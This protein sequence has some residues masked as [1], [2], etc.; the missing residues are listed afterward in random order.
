MSDAWLFSGGKIVTPQGEGPERRDLLLRDGMIQAI[1]EQID[2]PDDGRVVDCSGKL[3]LPGM[4]DMHVHAREPGR[5]DLE[6][7]RTASEA[8]INGGVTG[9]LAMPNTDP[10]V[11]TGSKIQFIHNLPDQNARIPVITAG[12]VSKNRSGNELAEIGDM[13]DKGALMITDDGDPV[14]DP[15]LLRRAMEYTRSFPLIV[16]THCE[17]P[18]LSGEGVVNEGRASYRLGLPG[19]PAVSEEICLERDLRL[20]Q[21][22]DASLHVHHMTTGEGVQLVRQFKEKG[23]DVTC[24]VTPHHLIFSSDDI[25]Q[26]NT[27]Y[28]MNPPLRRPEDCERLLEGLKQ[29]V[30]DCI[31]TDHAP[32]A[33]FEKRHDFMQAPFGILGLEVALLSLYTYLIEPG[34]LDWG[35]LVRAFSTRPRSLLGRPEL[36]FETGQAPD[37]LLFDTESTTSVDESY[38]RSKSSNTPFLN[39]EMDGSIELVVKRGEVLLDRTTGGESTSSNDPGEAEGAPAQSSLGAG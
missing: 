36:R 34:E 1:G 33:R 19:Q 14:E 20:A 3:I 30:V 16:G 35:T 9:L 4:F 8:A 24:E 29:G 12:C 18:A 39:T 21:F 11:D 23:V 38:L 28:K 37:F 2:A 32:H 15:V 13:V 22:T 26:H 7:I 27:Q 25:T 6:T 10:P 5:E 17:I 31:A